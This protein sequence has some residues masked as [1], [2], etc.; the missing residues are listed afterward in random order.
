MNWDRVQG[1]WKQL[2]GRVR[3]EWGKLTDDDLEV[4]Q[5]KR[6][7]LVGKLQVRYALLREEAEQRVEMWERRV[8]RVL[9]EARSAVS[10]AND[11]VPVKVDLEKVQGGRRPETAD[12]TERRPTS[13][14]AAAED[15]KSAGGTTRSPAIATNES[16]S[17]TFLS[18]QTMKSG[19]AERVGEAVGQ[20]LDDLYDQGKELYQESRDRVQTAGCTAGDY[21]Q[22]R[23]LSA[24]LMAAGVGLVL[25]VI[26]SRR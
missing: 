25:G 9:E 20:K 4:I 12:A 10:Q 15:H 13:A 26:L 18:E 24:L 21:V 8:E 1:N 17:G 16:R 5:G 6:D 19:K 11:A 2:K 3:E 7:R 23:P 22:E 14:R